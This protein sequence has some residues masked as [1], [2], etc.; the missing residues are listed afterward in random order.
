MEAVNTRTLK[1]YVAATTSPASLRDEE[2][3]VMPEYGVLIALIAVV[4]DTGRAARVI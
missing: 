3:Q 4:P 1:Q 2:G